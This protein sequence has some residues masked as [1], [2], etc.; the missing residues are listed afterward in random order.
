MVLISDKQLVQ[1]LNTFYLWCDTCDF[2]EEISL[3]KN[4]LTCAGAIPFDERSVA[5]TF[6]YTKARKSPVPDNICSHLL[7]SCADHLALY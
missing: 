2:S 7:P 6:K 4:K 3:L 5:N 1:E